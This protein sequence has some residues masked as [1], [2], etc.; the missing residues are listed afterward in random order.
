MHLAHPPTEVI[1]TTI[2]VVEDDHSIQ[3]LLRYVL[4]QEGFHILAV[5]DFA[6]AKAVLAK[7][8]YDLVV[9][10]INIPGGTGLELLY[11]LRKDFGIEVPVIMLSSLG[12]GH[13]IETSFEL[14]ATDYVTKPF[15][16][17]ELVLRIK[18][19]LDLKE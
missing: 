3:T 19:S 5:T 9:M 12:Q 8:G 6:M 16:P 14:G 1:Q 4:Q 18:R 17:R 2:L 13:N 7:G 11:L 10:D 15:N